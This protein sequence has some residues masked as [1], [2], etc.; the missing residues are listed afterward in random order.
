MAELPAFLINY[1]A[2]ILI[3]GQ[4]EGN[5]PSNQ[6]A[7]G[8]GALIHVGC[9]KCQPNSPTAEFKQSSPFSRLTFKPNQ[10]R[11]R[12]NDGR[13]WTG[14]GQSF[15]MLIVLP[16]VCIPN[17]NPF[18]LP[19]EEGGDGGGKVGEGEVEAAGGGETLLIDV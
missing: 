18:P 4:T 7:L 15:Q 5:T 9:A 2:L 8:A 3:R 6:K 11:L 19:A 12:V 10:L 17:R 13:Q 16:T 1:S 14:V